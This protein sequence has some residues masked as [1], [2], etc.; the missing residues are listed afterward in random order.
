MSLSPL[1]TR[2]NLRKLQNTLM[3]LD[4][5][6][7]IKYMVKTIHEPVAYQMRHSIQKGK[8][9]LNAR[10]AIEHRNHRYSRWHSYFYEK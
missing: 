9:S 5:V 6:E 3:V 4:Y 7:T 2:K 1:D 10:A 8:L